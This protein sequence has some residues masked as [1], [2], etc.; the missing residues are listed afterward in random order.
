MQYHEWEDPGVASQSHQWETDEDGWGS[1]CS[2]EAKS[3]AE[4][5]VEEVLSMLLSMYM[6]SVIPARTFCVL[7]YWLGLAGLP[8][9][10]YGMRPN[11]N[12]GHYKRH[13]DKVLGP[14]F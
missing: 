4:T 3:V 12:S 5:A 13:L 10:R 14:C 11:C 8:L 6:T 9:G 1:D 2:D 7:C